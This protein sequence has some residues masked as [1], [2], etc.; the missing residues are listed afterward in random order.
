MNLE[1]GAFA[2]CLLAERNSTLSLN[3]AEFEYRVR[4]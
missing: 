3:Q 1:F 2:H 4:A